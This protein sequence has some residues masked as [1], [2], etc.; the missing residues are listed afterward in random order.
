MSKLA[1]VKDYKGLCHICYSNITK[2]G[3]FICEE[4][5]I[6]DSERVVYT[7]SP[8][9]CPYCNY[10]HHY[11]KILKNME[12]TQEFARLEHHENR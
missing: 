1:I 7:V 8:A 4:I 11:L 12:V 5:Y 2:D 9:I 6:T 3:S 10:R